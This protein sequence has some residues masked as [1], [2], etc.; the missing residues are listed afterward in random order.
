MKVTAAPSI[1]QIANKY[2]FKCLKA[3][4]CQG[5][6]VLTSSDLVAAKS[7]CSNTIPA[8]SGGVCNSRQTPSASCSNTDWQYKCVD[9]NNNCVGLV[10][11]ASGYG[12]PKDGKDTCAITYPSCANNA[13]TVSEVAITGIY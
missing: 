5:T 9:V 11:V 7:A 13:C 10:A 8:C 2:Y 6:V 1:S 3:K 4:V 12:A